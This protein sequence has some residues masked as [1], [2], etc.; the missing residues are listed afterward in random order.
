M[1][2]NLISSSS[3]TTGLPSRW[4][5]SRAKQA[6][7]IAESVLRQ[8]LHKGDKKALPQAIARAEAA[9]GVTGVPGELLISTLMAATEAAYML[10][11]LVLAE[12]LAFR[13]S[14]SYVRLSL[15]DV[16]KVERLR[17]RIMLD[18]GDY[19]EAAMLAD[20]TDKFV[21]ELNPSI[22][23]EYTGGRIT[24]KKE[25]AKAHREGEESATS[26]ATWLL[27]AEIALLLDKLDEAM[28][29][30][31]F[32]SEKLHLKTNELQN[33]S[34]S[35]S[36]ES[37]LQRAALRKQVEDVREEWELYKLL[38]ALSSV[39]NRD[40]RGF[41]MLRVLDES[42]AESDEHSAVT[43][44]RVQAA[45]T[46]GE[47]PDFEPVGINQY[48]AARWRKLATM[49]SEPLIS[50]SQRAASESEQ[51]KPVTHVA[52]DV[53]HPATAPH[54]ESPTSPD[55]TAQSEVAEQAEAALDTLGAQLRRNQATP[56]TES[57]LSRTLMSPDKENVIFRGWLSHLPLNHIVSMVSDEK[58][59]C[60]V[61]LQWEE[62]IVEKAITEGL[63][64]ES[65]RNQSGRIY[66]QDGLFIDATL[67]ERTDNPFWREP[68][69]ALRQLVNLSLL[70]LEKISVVGL[71]TVAGEREQKIF[72]DNNTNL[73]LKL[74]TPEGEEDNT[75]ED[76][77][78]AF[79]AMTS[80]GVKIG[81]DLKV[82]AA[83]EG[84]AP[85]AIDSPVTS[86]APSSITEI[87]EPSAYLAICSAETQE[88]LC[89][90]IRDAL[91]AY[92]TKA[93]AVS[94]L[95]KDERVAG[96]ENASAATSAAGF[97]VEM[98]IAEDYKF[99]VW[100]E[101]E[102]P[103]ICLRAVLNVAAARLRSMPAAT[104][105][106]GLPLP[107]RDSDFIVGSHMMAS[108]IT[109]VRRVASLDGISQKKAHVLI[110]GE[111][112][113][114]KEL[115]AQQIYRYSG[116]VKM[117]FL[118]VSLSTVG[119]DVAVST[120]FGHMRGAFTD[121][122]EDHEGLIEQAKDG[123]IFLDEVSDIGVQE[124]LLRFIETGEFRRMGEKK[125]VRKSDVRVVFATSRNIQDPNLFVKDLVYRCRIIQVPPLRTHREDIR[126][127]AE[128]FA[129][130]YGVGISESAISWLSAQSWPGNVRHL[131]GVISEAAESIS[132][133]GTI[134][135]DSVVAAAS[136][137]EMRTHVDEPAL[138]RLLPNETMEQALERIHKGFLEQALKE[139][140]NNQ[141]RAATIFGV[142][143]GTFS[144][145][146]DTYG[147]QPQ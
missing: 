56:V 58:N 118:P 111:T 22:I 63:L 112:G 78:S 20:D 38:Q 50:Q 4:I 57:L 5:Q 129:A 21:F 103:E 18:R 60:V 54:V 134:S 124:M 65:V 84:S 108:L 1:V 130:P 37:M 16:A 101:S 119:R 34:T 25:E 135:L 88:D 131:K 23:E 109:R 136:I 8:L 33:N 93:A 82:V 2:L 79:N 71:A 36:N 47:S 92:G 97:N 52:D 90:A 122:R 66:F 125:G 74:S 51:I 10:G 27:R 39:Q 89:V 138:P 40:E 100:L 44:G 3:N 19:A 48:E 77:D 144:K 49:P 73:L 128:T 104:K 145:R 91:R 43:K 42:I 116:R 105:D 31:G 29:Y 117:P 17:A 35:T 99:C 55:I 142:K 28:R 62:E 95:V 7:E 98:E 120:I 139:A 137:Y 53:A 121:A 15:E 107:D 24:S 106:D 59:T 30:L 123:T 83:K 80:A 115:I 132:H 32:A 114:G 75:E 110:V 41:E 81:E 133:G 68:I 96:S 140:G 147:I 61:C 46:A 12:K 9:V 70:G 113:S 126:P 85:S 86:S 14:R 87:R 64:D 143:R 67:G 141:S 26:A 72:A 94:I 127:L 69:E 13:V 102:L 6:A 146:L 11:D 76:L 45:R